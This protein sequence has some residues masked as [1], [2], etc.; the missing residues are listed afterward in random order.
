MFW[1][2]QPQLR[3]RCSANFNCSVES[4]ITLR[5]LDIL[6][7]I[8]LLAWDIVVFWILIDFCFFLFLRIHWKFIF[9]NII[10]W[11]VKYLKTT[12]DK[13]W[14]F[15]KLWFYKFKNLSL[16]LFLESSDSRRCHWILQSFFLQLKNQRSEIKSVCFIF[17]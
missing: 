13:N 15:W 10:R 17:N 8:C 6:F 3:K 14:T 12:F 7:K 16:G 5:K 2:V 1:I 11:N 9:G 4:G